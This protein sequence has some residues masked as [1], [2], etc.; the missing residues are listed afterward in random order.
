MEAMFTAM[1]R[2]IARGKNL[3]RIS[4]KQIAPTLA[5]VMGLPT[6]ILG[7]VEKPLALR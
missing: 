1:G 6:D 3:G 7:S 5:E 2:E 4:L